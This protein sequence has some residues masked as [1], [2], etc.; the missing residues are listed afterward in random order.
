MCAITT[1]DVLQLK[2][3]V[4]RKFCLFLKT[5][6]N[7][8]PFTFIICLTTRVILGFGTFS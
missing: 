2:K 6:L 7:Q 5:K 1:T 3:S 8:Q 4:Q